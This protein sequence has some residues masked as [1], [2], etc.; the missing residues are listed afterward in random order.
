MGFVS[1]LFPPF[2]PPPPTV[3]AFEV[4]VPRR[5]LGTSQAVIYGRWKHKIS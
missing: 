2:P 1:P 5:H 4:E 3:R